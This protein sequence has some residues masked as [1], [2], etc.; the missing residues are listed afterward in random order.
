MRRYRIISGILLI[1]SIIDFALAAPVL[2]QEKRQARVDVVHVS[3]DVMTVLGKRWVQWL[4]ELLDEFSTRLPMGN[5]VE[6][7][8]AHTLSSS[9][10]PGP[11]HELTNEVEA[12]AQN[13]ASSTANSNPLTEPSSPSST[14][15]W[16][17]AHSNHEWL[18]DANDDLEEPMHTPASTDYGSDHEL[19][20]VVQA[21]A[22]LSPASSK[23][24]PNLLI[25]PLS[26][27]SKAS[28][29][30]LGDELSNHGLGWLD[31]PVLSPTST[32]HGSDY[33]LTGSYAL[34]PNPEDQ[35]FHWNHGMKLEDLSPLKW[36][37]TPAASS[38]AFVDFGQTH[39]YHVQQVQRPD[40]L[41]DPG[42]S[43]PRPSIDPAFYR[44]YWMR[45][46]DANW[47]GPVLPKES[48][49]AHV[50]SGGVRT[51][52]D[53]ASS[54]WA[55]LQKSWASEDLKPG[56]RPIFGPYLEPED[57]QRPSRG[58]SDPGPSGSKPAPPSS[59]DSD[60]DSDRMRLK[61][62]PSTPD[63]GSSDSEVAQLVGPPGIPDMT[64]E[65]AAR[66]AVKGKA[67]IL[68]RISGA[69]RNVGNAVG[70]E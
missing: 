6:S 43:S 59:T 60:S 61:E 67:K 23:A 62:I 55:W 5:P 15:S 27:S 13:P 32:D 51:W 2:V 35:G 56:P 48:G 34:Q 14:A 36:P 47:Q 17:D 38:N 24:N 49:Q 12:P 57:V 65:Q 63:Q 3:R 41:S 68:S 45:L 19:T 54:V 52:L 66:Y 50:D 10:Q 26:P 44:D 64:D 22:A 20:N 37:P 31:K 9:T 42:L 53:H 11:E 46:E 39:E 70:K 8:E 25:E 16:G 4:P 1:L 29:A 40:E 30:S 7:S 33:K 21:P 28:T 18:E 69:T 58:P